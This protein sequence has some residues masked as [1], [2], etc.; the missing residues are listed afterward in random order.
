MAGAAASAPQGSVAH[1]GDTIDWISQ[2]N[3]MIGYL[4][5]TGVDASGVDVD[6]WVWS[7]G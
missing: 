3:D 1:P 2:N 5:V 7:K 6:M 4:D